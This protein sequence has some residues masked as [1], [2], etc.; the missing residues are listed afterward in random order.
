M[1]ADKIRLVSDGAKKCMLILLLDQG[2]NLFTRKTNKK[3]VFWST[4]VGVQP[5]FGGAASRWRRGACSPAGCDVNPCRRCVTR[6]AVSAGSKAGDNYLGVLFR[7]EVTEGGEGGDGDQ[8][9]R[10]QLI[11]KGMPSSAKRRQEMRVVTLFD[12]EYRMHRDV[13][14]ALTR[15]L[16]DCGDERVRPGPSFPYA[17]RW[18]LGR[19]YTDPHGTVIKQPGS[20]LEWRRLSPPRCVDATRG[21]AEG[22]DTLVMQDL[23]PLGFVMH[24]RRQ[25]LDAAHVATVF[26]SLAYLHAASLA[27]QADRPADFNAARDALCETLFTPDNPINKQIALIAPRTYGRYRAHIGHPDTLTSSPHVASI[28]LYFTLCRPAPAFVADRFPEDSEGYRK[29]KDFIDDFPIAMS[30]LVA[31]STAGVNTITHGDC[32]TNNL[33]FRYSEASIPNPALALCP[34]SGI[35]ADPSAAVCF[36]GRGR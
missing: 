8:P 30:D 20:K 18:V 24:D 21:G 15:Y 35:Y 17:P 6:Y 5:E 4:W 32:W 12:N 1:P 10:L 31:P 33:L 16:A 28:Y 36:A 13:L 14:P 22:E 26:R 3:Q 27:M 9:P 11:L 19:T 2:K 7:V 29:L 25:G 23:R 34:F